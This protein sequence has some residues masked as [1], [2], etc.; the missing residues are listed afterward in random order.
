[1]CV[2]C[3]VVWGP[4]QIALSTGP[5]VQNVVYKAIKIRKQE[6][7]TSTIERLL[8]LLVNCCIIFNEMKIVLKSLFSRLSGSFFI[9][10]MTF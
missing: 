8:S 9:K 6:C 4:G 1:M 5:L 7:T 2:D 3:D 10:T